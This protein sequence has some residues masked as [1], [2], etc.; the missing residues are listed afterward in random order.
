M[1]VSSGVE[2]PACMVGIVSAALAVLHC[3]LCDVAVLHCKLCDV[4]L[5]ASA[6][7]G[8]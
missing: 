5:A 3:K 4:A 1:H 8:A 6:D 2:L 7:L